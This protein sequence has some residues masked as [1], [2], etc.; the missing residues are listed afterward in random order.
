MEKA[1]SPFIYQHPFVGGALALGFFIAFA[2]LLMVWWSF[3]L[4]GVLIFRYSFFL[5]LLVALFTNA[6]LYLSKFNKFK[7]PIFWVLSVGAWV[8]T[9]FNKKKKKRE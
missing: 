3:V 4:L 5:Y 2:P 1:L 8:S 7:H 6:S 9:S